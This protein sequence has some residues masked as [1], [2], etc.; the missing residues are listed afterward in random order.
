MPH[1]TD[2]APLCVIGAAPAVTSRG[3]ADH[4]RRLRQGGVDA[5]LATAGAVEA[6]ADALMAL[7]RWWAA[8]GMPDEPVR[9]ATTV[10]AM[11]AA[12]SEGDTAVVLHFQ[13]SSMLGGEVALVDAYYQLGVRVMQLTYN[14][15]AEAG[16]GCLEDNDAGLSSFG[17]K[18]LARMEKLGILPDVSHAGERTSRDILRLADGPVIASHSNPRALCNSPRNLTDDLIDAIAASGGVIGICAFPA[19]LVE[20]GRPTAENMADHISYI[21]ERIGIEHVGLGLDFADE[22]EDDYDYY[23]YD[24]RYYPRPPWA[25][26]KGLE[27]WEDVKNLRSVLAHRGFHENQIDGVMGRE[28]PASIQHRLGPPGTLIHAVQ[29]LT[30][31][32]PAARSMS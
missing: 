26:P 2:A 24:K 1:K 31:I 19:F 10:S 17:R 16:D 5:V 21:A 29:R 22:D 18:V 7:G 6:P 28:L 20:S 27:W 30:N 32:P 13:G 12:A 25:W 3:I 11:R 23:G 4:H 8:D 15:R 9:I 14:Y